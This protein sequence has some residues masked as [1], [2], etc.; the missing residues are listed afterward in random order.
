MAT[1]RMDLWQLVNALVEKM[2]LTPVAIESV[3]GFALSEEDR[4]DAFVHYV[5]TGRVELSDGVVAS[6]LNLLTKPSMQFDEKSA[7]AF[8]IS[9][10]CIGIGVA[11]EKYGD[12]MVTQ[13][14]RGQS[15]EETT[16]YSKKFAWGY[17]S[18]AFKADRPDCLLRVSFRKQIYGY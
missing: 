18:F 10:P 17:L 2:P 16:V 9:G 14:P 12:L 1:N 5:G 15:L 4:S 13:H 8:E 3:F 6:Q 7:F 11:R